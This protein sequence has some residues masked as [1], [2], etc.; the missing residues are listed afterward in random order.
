MFFLLLPKGE[1]AGSFTISSR[2]I[3]LALFIHCKLMRNFA[4]LM[5][6]RWEWFDWQ[7]EFLVAP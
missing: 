4:R 3:D 5:N 6:E 2:I 7:S 1:L